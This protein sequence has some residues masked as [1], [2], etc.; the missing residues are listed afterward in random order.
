MQGAGYT[1]QGV[2]DDG[3][4]NSSA[5]APPPAGD[6]PQ[7]PP[8]ASLQYGP[9][10]LSS[11]TPGT[12]A[13]GAVA[14]D[15]PS[16]LDVRGLY[17]NPVGRALLNGDHVPTTGHPIVALSASPL[18]MDSPMAQPAAAASTR[19]APSRSFQGDRPPFPVPVYSGR[20]ADGSDVEQGGCPRGG[21]VAAGDR[22][23]IPPGR[24]STT[25]IG[26]SSHPYGG[27]WSSDSSSMPVAQA[28]RAAPPMDLTIQ[29]MRNGG[30]LESSGTYCTTPSS[31]LA[32][33]AV[34]AA[35]PGWAG[36][37]PTSA[38]AIP[39]PQQSRAARRG[40]GATP[41]TGRRARA[42]ARSRSPSPKRRGTAGPACGPA[43][44]AQAGTHVTI[45]IVA[46]AVAA[47]F[48]AVENK[49]V[50]LQ[51]SV[52]GLSNVVGTSAGKLDNFRVL[53]QSV[54]T[55][56]GVTTAALAELKAASNS[57]AGPSGG[58]GAGGSAQSAKEPV[59]DKDAIAR[60]KADQVKVCYERVKP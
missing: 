4:P 1:A 13:G 30:D 23:T 56:Q 33:A 43:A 55:A 6:V 46:R 31:Y 29:P 44:A 51:K 37:A 34:P 9:N 32:E 12:T 42:G 7:T 52:D 36:A 21:A 14:A 49:L 54:T 11:Y 58:A 48:K 27:I 17:Y 22:S 3:S 15:D 8:S 45:D 35:A 57:A 53:A 28:R 40:S 10:G 38:A 19:A 24:L 26:H 25:H 60:A 47:G 59:V 41:P 20:R 18:S 16:H 50:R 5:Y 39:I 2:R